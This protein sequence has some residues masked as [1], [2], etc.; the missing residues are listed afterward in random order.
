[1]GATT[2][3]YWRGR[4]PAGETV[5]GETA[6]ENRAE[7]LSQLR[8]RRIAVSSVQEKGGAMKFSLPSLGLGNKV[9]T[10]DVATFTRQFSVMLKAGLPLVL[11]LDT[12]ARQSERPVMRETLKA[13]KEEVE[14]G[15]TLADS[16]RQ[17]RK[18]FGDLYVQMVHAGETG[19]VLDVILER[20]SDYLEK[21]DSLQRKVK[22]AM[23][24]PAV[25]FT[26]AI[27]AS[28]FMLIA[29]IPNFAKMFADFG[30]TLPGPT[31]VVLAASQILVK[32]WWAMALAIVAGVVGLKR[33]RATSA[34]R[35]KTD[36]LLLQI[37]AIGQII[38]K[39]A[40]A[41]FT[42]T[43]GTLISSGA[44]LLES[45]Q[46]TA[47]TSGSMVLREAVLAT[48]RSISSGNTIA[49]PLRACG[50]FP[51][52]AVQMISVG[53]ETG[54]LDTMLNR[55]AEFYDDEVDAA[56]AGLTSIIEPVM[57]V[58]MGG[59]VGGMVIAMYLPIFKMITVVGK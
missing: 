21:A 12:L 27:G 59:V 34:G 18:I 10:R 26:V 46:T 35:L 7:L 20:L 39:S 57:I 54:A 33:Y 15:S 17:H 32:F 16:L 44:P 4:N 24:Y 43:L 56:V 55:V 25:V 49:E 40:V 28:A 58:L 52:M 53:E 19:G 42:R 41:R 3:Y 13:V 29:I 6:A 50:V 36:R 47:D 22:S 37:P 2:T 45:L 1:M 23:M 30:G 51:P 8:R 31:R 14:A 9:K 48:R 38:R 11:C 5:S